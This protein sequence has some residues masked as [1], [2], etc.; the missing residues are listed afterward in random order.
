MRIAAL[1]GQ[2]KVKSQD[3]NFIRSCL[4]KSLGRKTIC[5]SE[6]HHCFPLVAGPE[7]RTVILSNR[8][9]LLL[10]FPLQ[11]DKSVIITRASRRRDLPCRNQPNNCW[12]LFC[13]GHRWHQGHGRRSLSSEGSLPPVTE[14]TNK[15]TWQ[16]ER[17]EGDEAREA[18]GG[19]SHPPVKAKLMKAGEVYQTSHLK[20]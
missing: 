6:G 8:S 19:G 9:Q 12:L 17:W 4:I 3:F 10:L 14:R 11:Y 20:T 15:V 16:T 1:P 18:G 5:S 2:T 13:A 7:R